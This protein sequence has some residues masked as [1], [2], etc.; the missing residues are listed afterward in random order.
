MPVGGGDESRF[1]QSTE[2]HF[3]PANSG[4]YFVDSRDQHLKLF[5][6]GTRSIKTI[7]E[8]PGPIG[9]EFGISSDEQWVSFDK[10]DRA[11]SELMLVENF[12]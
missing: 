9:T 1:L 6:F 8:V 10:L 7:A 3:A 5:D 11:G 12:H 2:Q 4:V